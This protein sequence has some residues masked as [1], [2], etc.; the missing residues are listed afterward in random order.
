V[1]L[2]AERSRPAH[3]ASRGRRRGRRASRAR[4]GT[5]AALA[6]HVARSTAWGPLL[7]GCLSG[8]ALTVALRAAAGPS[9][10]QLLGGGIRASFVPVMAGLAFVLHDPHRLLT[11]A[12][13]ARAW[14]TPALRLG[15]VLPVVGLSCA[16]QMLLGG[17]ALAAGL[18]AAGQPPAP[19]PWPALTG[20]LAAWCLLALAL[21]AGLGRTRWHDIAGVAA[22]LGAMALIGLTGLVPFH[23]LPAAITGM[24][25][26]QHRQWVTA[27]QFW[28]AAGV[29]GA[30]I[31]GW[32]AGDPWR[33][34]RPRTRAA[35]GSVGI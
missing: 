13:P 17:R 29:I 22:A 32:A 12:L 4:R 35:T 15:L 2:I 6:G 27:C 19:L 9:E 26:A 23:L 11:G 20:E 5:K 8:V 21:S 30:A 31:I 3:A 1:P 7:A 24:S 33:R 28:V 34:I 18:R 25:S 16:I 14:W 10:I